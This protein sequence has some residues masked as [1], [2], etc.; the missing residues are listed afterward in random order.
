V[1]AIEPTERKLV[2]SAI[3]TYR[4]ALEKAGYE[5]SIENDFSAWRDFVL[6]YVAKVP[7]STY[8]PD[9]FPRRSETGFYVAA[10]VDGCVIAVVAN[11]LFETDNWFRFVRSGGLWWQSPPRS[12]RPTVVHPF[13]NA[14]GIDGRVS[15]CGGGMIDPEYRGQGLPNILCRWARL[16]GVKRWQP[17]WDTATIV[18]DP[19][20]ARNLPIKYGYQLEVPL[21]CGYSAG[22][23]APARVNLVSITGS[24]IINQARNDT[25]IFEVHRGEDLRDLA[26]L[27]ADR[28]EETF[29]A[30]VNIVHDES[31][32]LEYRALL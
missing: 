28:T 10:K 29:I 16:E 21:I 17:S 24:G 26:R 18:Q 6:S 8:D 1:G 14:L 7:N 4:S 12:V 2:E 22:R 11:R 31:D 20:P 5:V 13:A 30:A 32:L 15:H 23:G 27:V 3:S 9:R 19:Q 25:A